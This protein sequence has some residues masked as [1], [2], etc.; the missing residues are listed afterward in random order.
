MGKLIVSN[1][2]SI[3]G[4]YEGPRR[5]LGSLFDYFHPDYA[6]DEVFDH[7]NT[8]RLRAADVV[9]FSGRDSFVGNLTYWTGVLT[10]PN[11]TKIRREFASLLRDV[12]KLVVS[13]RLAA[14]DLAPWS[15]ARIVRRAEAHQ[16]VAD[17]KQRTQRDIFLFGGR[18]LW[19]DLLAHDLVDELHLM[20][21][22]LVAGSGT[23]AFINRPTVAFKLLHSR[24]WQGSGLILACYQVRRDPA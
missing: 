9:L 12:D 19:N 18:T 5:D 8:E 4:Y 16:A 15:D 6:G 11:A 22:P 2:L 1:L 21:F 23:P 10:D 17:L 14:E 7:Y 13:D 24:T 3:D 20:I